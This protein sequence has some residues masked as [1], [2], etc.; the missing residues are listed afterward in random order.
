MVHG[1]LREGISV[2]R[3]K[4]Q[5]MITKKCDKLEYLQYLKALELTYPHIA[6]IQ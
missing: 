3:T 1:N 4:H 6:E 2:Y 5:I